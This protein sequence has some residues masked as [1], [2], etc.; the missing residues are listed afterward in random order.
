MKKFLMSI[1][2]IMFSLSATPLVSALTSGEGTILFG[3]TFTILA[4]AIFFLLLSIMAQNVP[5]KVFF[6][7]LS[8]LVL[9]GS[10]GFAV[11]IMQ[12]FFGDFTNLVTS[13]GAFYRLLT[14]LLMG[15]SIA[16]ILWLVVVALRSFWSNR[17][18]MDSEL[19]K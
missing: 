18:M 8:V 9:V 3:A 7:S 10:V 6:L 19:M 1:L 15:G 14:I 13:Y 11:G 17:G 5:I 2:L 12:Q 16:L 4:T